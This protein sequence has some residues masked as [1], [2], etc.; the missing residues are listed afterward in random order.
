MANGGSEDF[1]NAAAALDG[2]LH[3]GHNDGSAKFIC[4][5]SDAQLVRSG[6]IDVA[7]QWLDRWHKAGTYILWV[8][9]ASGY[10]GKRWL[11]KCPGV[12]YV[13]VD[14]NA[15]RHDPLVLVNA[16]GPKLQE[17]MRPKS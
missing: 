11:D 16:I 8:G 13:D 1:D 4:I 15:V 10:N 12:I 3:L 17:A 14:R 2:V 6:E 9:C 5:I 7:M